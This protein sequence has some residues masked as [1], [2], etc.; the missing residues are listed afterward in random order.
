MHLPDP[1]ALLPVVP[2]AAQVRG[3]LPQV[4]AARRPVRTVRK[5]RHGRPTATRLTVR[6]AAAHGFTTRTQMPA[7][8]ARRTQSHV[9]VEP[10]MGS[11][12]QTAAPRST[13]NW[14][15]L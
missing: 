9:P 14:L 15:R 11:A 5:L 8:S 7:N 4:V 12:T 10:G 1:R 2:A 3:V 13:I 6:P